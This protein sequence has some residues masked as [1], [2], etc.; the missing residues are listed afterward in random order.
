MSRFCAYTLKIH[1][2]L[3]VANTSALCYDRFSSN[4][5]IMLIPKEFAE[6]RAVRRSCKAWRTDCTAMTTV[7]GQQHIYFM[8]YVHN[9][10]QAKPRRT[11][12][13][14]Q[15]VTHLTA[16]T[17][18]MIREL[19]SDGRAGSCSSPLLLLPPDLLASTSA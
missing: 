4:T 6:Q 7:E 2:L 10:L 1:C 8:T 19:S 5:M 18:M 16:V 12:Q 14:S 11:K 13:T 17:V 3:L 15:Q 9:V